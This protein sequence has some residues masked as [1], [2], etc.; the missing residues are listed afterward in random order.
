MAKSLTYQ[1]TLGFDATP[2]DST[3]TRGAGLVLCH[4]RELRTSPPDLDSRFA[5]YLKDSQV[6]P[7]RL[8]R[9]GSE[10]PGQERLT[11]L[12]KL[13][14]EIYD[15]RYT[16]DIKDLQVPAAKVSFF[17]SFQT[18]DSEPWC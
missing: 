10:V 15:A 8:G 14:E 17:P 3:I 5:S 13:I 7:K 6:R 16:H 1:N 12:M 4:L 2:F 18:G 11:W 9:P